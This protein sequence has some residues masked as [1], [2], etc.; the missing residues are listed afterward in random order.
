MQFQLVNSSCL[1]C[2]LKLVLSSCHCVWCAL[3]CNSYCKNLKFL[4]SHSSVSPQ[5]VLESWFWAPSQSPGF[6]SVGVQSTNFFIPGVGVPQKIESTSLLSTHLNRP[7]IVCKLVQHTVHERHSM[8]SA[9]IVHKNLD[10]L[11]LANFW[12][13]VVTYISVLSN[14][15]HFTAWWK[16]SWRSCELGLWPL[17][18][19]QESFVTLHTQSFPAVFVWLAGPWHPVSEC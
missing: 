15:Y 19:I 17:E 8:F 11:V 9:N 18:H 5:E 2:Y 12:W 1:S 13:V 6:F 10:I 4:S 7:V 16:Y 14:L 3:L